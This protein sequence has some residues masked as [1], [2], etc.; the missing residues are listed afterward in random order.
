MFR[1]FPSSCFGSLLREFQENLSPG[2]LSCRTRLQGADPS[3]VAH[4]FDDPQPALEDGNDDLTFGGRELSTC[5]SLQDGIHGPG[6][7]CGGGNRG[8]S[9]FHEVILSWRN[10]SLHAQ[11]HGRR[12]ALKSQERTLSRNRFAMAIEHFLQ[13]DGRLVPAPFWP[14]PSACIARLKCAV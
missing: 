7:F 4:R 5:H 6:N 13:S 3:F 9:K 10:Q 8:Q 14:S 1:I 11:T 2:W 12:I